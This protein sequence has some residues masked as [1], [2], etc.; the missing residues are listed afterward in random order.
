MREFAISDVPQRLRDAEWVQYR[1]DLPSVFRVYDLARRGVIPCV[2]IGKSVKFDPVTIEE[3]IRAG[4]SRRAVIDAE[5][6]CQQP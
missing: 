4:G 2:R 1:L 6:Q 3:W 5:R